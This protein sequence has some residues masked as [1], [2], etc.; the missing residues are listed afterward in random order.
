MVSDTLA[1]WKRGDMY[2]YCTIDDRIS[3]ARKT[4][5]LEE[6]LLLMADHP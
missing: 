1:Y 6:L 3:T 5:R 2:I 4:L